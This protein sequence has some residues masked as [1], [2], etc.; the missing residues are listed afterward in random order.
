MAGAFTDVAAKHGSEA[1][2]PFYYA[3]TMGLVQR[4]GINRLRHVMRYSRQKLTICTS[5]AELGWAAGVGRSWGPDPREMAKSDLIVIW[6]GNPVATQ[7]N[8]MTHVSRARKERGA[9]LVVVDP[10]RSGNRGGGGSAHRTAARHRW[11]A[12]L[13]D[14]ARG[15]PR[16]FR[17]SRIYGAVCR[18][19][20]RVG[21]ASRVARAGMGGGDHR[22]ARATDRGFRTAVLRHRSV[23]T[24]ASATASRAARNGAANMHAVSCLPTVTG[25]WQHEGGGALWS[26]RGM[27]H[28]DKTLIEGLDALDPSIRIMDMSRI[29]SVLTGD[30]TELRD[31]PP[32]HALLIQNQNP[33]TVCPDSNRVRRGFAAR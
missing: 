2:W 29:G 21:S 20:G 13:R 25:K 22:F 23:A 14:D 16:W 10:Y 12:G 9:K 30:R 32:V 27:Y 28:W 7:V 11:R 33:L 3:G 8:V 31:G 18:L 1:V 24:S 19:P 15:V 17:R 26:N 5:L 4:D 6:G